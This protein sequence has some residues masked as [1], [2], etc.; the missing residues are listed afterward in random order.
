MRHALSQDN[1]GR[2]PQPTRS[3]PK[4]NGP[5]IRRPRKYRSWGDLD[6]VRQLADARMTSGPRSRLERHN[7]FVD[8]VIE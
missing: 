6:S 1:L 3:D 7:R 5:R 2:D 8:E 4:R